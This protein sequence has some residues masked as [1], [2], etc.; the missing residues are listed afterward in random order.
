VLLGMKPQKIS[1]QIQ[2]DYGVDIDSKLISNKIK[3][4]KVNGRIKVPAVDAANSRATDTPYPPVKW[5]DMASAINAAYSIDERDDIEIEAD[6]EEDPDRAANDAHLNR[7]RNMGLFFTKET[8]TSLILIISN[9]PHSQFDIAIQDENHVDVIFHGERP[10]S[11]LFHD[12][13]EF[14]GISPEEWGL[15]SREIL[16]TTVSVFPSKKLSTDHAKI[17][18]KAYPPCLPLHYVIKIPFFVNMP[19]PNLHFD[20]LLIPN[21]NQN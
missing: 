9:T 19:E 13:H 17:T 11:D 14:I 15:E 20:R 4:W 6:G 16:T 10:P 1:D 8:S 2:H 12:L 5:R 7:L 3:N 21:E 18:R